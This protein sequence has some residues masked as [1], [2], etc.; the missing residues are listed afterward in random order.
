MTINGQVVRA[1]FETY[2][3]TEEKFLQDAWVKK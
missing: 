3:E 1:Q 2:L